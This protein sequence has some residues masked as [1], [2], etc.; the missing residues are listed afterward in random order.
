MVPYLTP[1]SLSK[2]SQSSRWP[3]AVNVNLMGY[4]HHFPVYQSVVCTAVMVD[5][6]T[7][8]NVICYMIFYSRS[9]S[10]RHSTYASFVTATRLSRLFYGSRDPNLATKD[11][12]NLLRVRVS[13]HIN[14]I[15]STCIQPFKIVLAMF[16]FRLIRRRRSAKTLVYMLIL[17]CKTLS[18]FFR[19]QHVLITMNQQCIMTAQEISIVQFSVKKISQSS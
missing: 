14:I 8:R 5:C 3:I 15:S 1:L 19:R 13:D 2:V 10:V 4:L 7:S 17:I 18:R 11:V 16:Y 12:R 6:C 9:F